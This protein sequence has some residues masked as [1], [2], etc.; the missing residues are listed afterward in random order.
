MLVM[1]TPATDLP[2]QQ[3][4]DGA[5]LRVENL[6]THFPVRGGGAVKAVDGVMFHVKRRCSLG[7][8]GESGCGKSTLARTILRLIPA[9]SGKVIFDGRDV[10][11]L[12]PKQMRRL[13]RE[14]QII[15]QDPIGSLNPRMNVESLVGEA[16]GVHGLVNT[17]GE[18]RKRVADLLTHVGLS[19]N[20][21]RRYPHEFSGGQRQRIGIAR[22][23]ALKPKLIICDE[24]VSALDVSIQSQILNLLADLQD[25]FGL[26]YLFIAHNLAVVRHFCD[27]IAVM[28]LGKIVEQASAEELFSNPRHPYTQALLAAAPV[29]DPRARR[30]HLALPGEPPNPANPP[31]GCAFHPRCPIAIDCCRQET[32]NL[33]RHAAYPTDHIIACHRAIEADKSQV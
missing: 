8:V 21:L 7:L 30:D 19:P 9:T 14:M 23:L 6:R 25:E 12:P 10:L 24:P 26:S 31:T 32:P 27:E 2:A 16:L 5:I 20:D 4:T 1:T 29:P 33:K 18:R 28:Y 3:P 11:A 13:R 22:A 15:F 17:R